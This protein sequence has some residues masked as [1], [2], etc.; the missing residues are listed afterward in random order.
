MGA[1]RS[2]SSFRARSPT[3]RLRA[4]PGTGGCR[5][6]EVRAG[7]S[8]P[9]TCS[10]ASSSASPPSRATSCRRPARSSISPQPTGIRR[11]ARR[12]SSPVRSTPSM[13]GEA[14]AAA[15]PGAARTRARARARSRASD[16]SAACRWH[17]R[18]LAARAKLPRGL[19]NSKYRGGD[20]GT[21]EG[22][23]GLGGR[24]RATSCRDKDPKRTDPFPALGG[25]I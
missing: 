4:E 10:A 7:G 6:A 9:S 2:A 3:V 23:E 5:R 14:E 13:P 21:V 15:A 24:G 19:P 1:G 12:A 11:W 8:R 22:V 20:R 16:L 25:S 17:S 18:P